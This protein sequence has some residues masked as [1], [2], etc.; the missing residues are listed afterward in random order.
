[1]A[2]WTIGQYGF[3]YTMSSDNDYDISN[4]GYHMNL[5]EKDEQLIALLKQN[6]RM[7]VSELA[8]RL[9]GS[10]TAVQKRLEKLERNQ[11]IAGY[12]AVLSRDYQDKMVRALVMI[13]FSPR[14]R[15]QIE[16]RLAALPQLSALYS[17]S[18]AFDMATVISAH[19]M[20]KLDQLIDDIGCLDGIDETMSSIILST[21]IDR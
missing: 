8:R 9:S 12:T 16:S 17:I 3:Y 20:S 21:K 19:S 15:S 1:M 18:G 7:P 11:V 10:R 13:K 6:G 2:R 4:N 5:T 14:E